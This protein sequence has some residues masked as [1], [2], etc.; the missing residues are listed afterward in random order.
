MKFSN[1]LKKEEPKN[2]ENSDSDEP[3]SKIN[4]NNLNNEYFEGENDIQNGESN[5]NR[6]R[7]LW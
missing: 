2:K 1:S 7:L 4:N 3:I 5:K 6:Q